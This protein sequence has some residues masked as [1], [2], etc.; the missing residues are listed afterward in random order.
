MS[1]EAPTAPVGFRCGGVLPAET[2]AAMLVAAREA[3]AA[4]A[5]EMPTEADALAVMH[6]AFTRL[7]ELGWR[8]AASAPVGKPLLLIE[9]GSTGIHHGTR[10]KERRFWIHDR[11]TWPSRPVLYK[12]ES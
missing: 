6:R 9:A 2:V 3:Q 7:R 1:D 11:D 5:E 4:R 12:E 10:D 8:D